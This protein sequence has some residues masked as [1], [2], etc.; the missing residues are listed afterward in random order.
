M[1]D[2]NVPL[3][4]LVASAA[5]LGLA[6]G[7]FAA[8]VVCRLPRMVMGEVGLSLSYPASHCTACRE[9]LRWVHNIPVLSYFFLKGR[10]GFCGH[11]IGRLSV[12][13]ELIFAILWAAF[14]AVMGRASPSTWVWPLFFSVLLV[15]LLI[16]WQ[17]MLLPDALTL[18][19]ALFGVLCAYMN[20]TGLSLLDS[21]LGAL[22]GYSLLRL[23]VYV[24]E[25][26]R[27]VV[28]MGGGDFKLMAALG[29][30]LGPQALC[31]LLLISSVLHIA[32]A[33]WKSRWISGSMHG[34]GLPESAVPFGP[35]LIVAAMLFWA[36]TACAEPSVAH[37]SFKVELLQD[38]ALT[39]VVARNNGPAV[40]SVEVH[41]QAKNVIS[42]KPWPLLV[43]VP[44]FSELVL[45]T[46]SAADL[47]SEYQF[48]IRTNRVWGD[49]FTPLDM[50]PLRLPF[51]NRS[52]YEINQAFGGL[53][54]THRDPKLQYAI[55]FDMPEGSPVAAARDGMVVEVTTGFTVGELDL[56]LADHANFVKLLHADGSLTTYS[57]LSPQTT[58]L[59]VG[60]IFRAGEM[61]GLSGNTGYSSGPHLHFCLSKPARSPAGLTEAC[62]PV[63]FA[64]GVPAQVFSPVEGM[65]V[66][67]ND[68]GP[69]TVRF[70]ADNRGVQKLASAATAFGSY[71][72]HQ[73][74][75]NVLW[76]LWELLLMIPWYVYGCIFYIV[77]IFFK[78]IF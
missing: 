18:P 20:W 27:G 61:I 16:D 45:A 75:N 39:R 33:T 14:V 4:V 73:E 26:L 35:G 3:W 71:D 13:L 60:Q 53:M 48:S 23:I 78:I 5:T 36:A 22:L 46:V 51:A 2:L 1:S 43:V 50:T 65:L 40:V 69:A 30:W 49:I 41:M 10:C 34:D 9:P 21:V 19:L 54:T 28:A 58:Q 68:N 56:M 67:A 76:S 77:L 8:L 6:L 37:Y 17:A 24:F 12:V 74:S 63:E 15:L 44:G 70:R 29:A 72:L 66:Q 32:L 31:W 57:H 55:D 47:L 62:L 64:S 25:L 52:T 11:P 7:S 42:D 38:G 59:T